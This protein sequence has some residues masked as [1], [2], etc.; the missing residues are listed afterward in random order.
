MFQDNARLSAENANLTEKLASSERANGRLIQELDGV[1]LVNKTK[2]LLLPVFFSS[3]VIDWL[4]A[5]YMSLTPVL[6]KFS[7]LHHVEYR[8]P[9]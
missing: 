7:L 2:I 3:L 6:T 1:S 8:W 9:N 5:V 4:N